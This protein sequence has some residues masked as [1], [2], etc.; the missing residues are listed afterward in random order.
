MFVFLAKFRRGLYP[1]VT[2]Q[3]GT[4]CYRLLQIK[5]DSCVSFTDPIRGKSRLFLIRRV[6][7][8]NNQQLVGILLDFKGRLLQIFCCQNERASVISKVQGR[9]IHHH[10]KIRVKKSHE[11]I[12]GVVKF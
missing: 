9:H 6:C 2:L 3:S 12:F 4:C 7:S 10:L 1:P 8:Q 11:F 5:Y